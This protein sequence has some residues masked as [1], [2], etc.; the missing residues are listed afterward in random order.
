MRRARDMAMVEPIDVQLFEGCGLAVRAVDDAE[1]AAW[2]VL[3][4]GAE[5][6]GVLGSITGNIGKTGAAA[7]V[8]GLIKAVLAIAN[9][10]LPPSAGVRAPHPVLRDGRPALRLS[11]TP[12]RWPPGTRHAGVGAAGPDGLAVPLVLRG[13][14]DERT[15]A[16]KAPPLRSRVMPR[17]GKARP[18]S[19]GWAPWHTR[20]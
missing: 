13:E 6:V 20:A 12:E 2:A 8:A 11:C 3:R 9:G 10:V 14:P 19:P 1:I 4:A 18:P 7:G 15:A 16:I 5:R 17:A